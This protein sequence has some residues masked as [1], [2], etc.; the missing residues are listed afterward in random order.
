M[1]GNKLLK[2]SQAYPKQFGA[3]TAGLFKSS[4][5]SISTTSVAELKRAEW[6]Y[7]HDLKARQNC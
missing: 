5:K 2:G 6:A 1:S 3:A 4:A 7:A